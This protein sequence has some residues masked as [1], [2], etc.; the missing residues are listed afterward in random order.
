MTPATPS[1][2]ERISSDVNIVHLQLFHYYMSEEGHSSIPLG[3]THSKTARNIVP[4]YAFAYP[5]LLHSMLAFSARCLSDQMDNHEEK[6][7]YQLLASSL[8]SKALAGFNEALPHLSGSNCAAYVLFSHTIGIHSFYETFA[9]RQETAGN[10]LRNLMHTI[11]LMRGVR[12]VVS[13]FWLDFQNSDLGP[14]VRA[15][16]A[17]MVAASSDGPEAEHL[18]RLL[19]GADLSPATRE[20]YIEAVGRLQKDINA[21]PEVDDP[22]NAMSSVFS[23]LISTPQEFSTLLEERRPEALVLLGWFALVLHR[24]RTSPMIGDSGSYLF[25]LVDSHL[26][27]RWDTWM[28]WPRNEIMKER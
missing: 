15:A 12:L 20:I 23:W 28:A 1:A 7:S 26:G 21:H 3:Q 9:S 6:A 17:Q 13:P 8:Q 16:H 5:F 27:P 18:T 2:P 11:N 10:F 25:G 22:Q 4:K 14:I 24:H 19:D